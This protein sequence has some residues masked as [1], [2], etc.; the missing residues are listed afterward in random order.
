MFRLSWRKHIH[1]PFLVFR[2]KESSSTSISQFKM[3][4][5]TAPHSAV[6][7]SDGT[8]AN[9]LPVPGTHVSYHL[10]GHRADNQDLPFCDA[11]SILCWE[12][13]ASSASRIQLGVATVDP[14][15]GTQ[16]RLRLLLENGELRETLGLFGRLPAAD[17]EKFRQESALGSRPERGD[18]TY[19]F[20]S[21][22]GRKGSAKDSER[23]REGSARSSVGEGHSDHHQV[24]IDSPEGTGEEAGL[25][26]MYKHLFAL[27]G[28]GR[29][30]I[31]KRYFLKGANT[32][33]QCDPAKKRQALVALELTPALL[34]G[35]DLER[36]G[37]MVQATQRDL[38][39]LHLSARPR[40]A[41]RRS[42]R[43]AALQTLA[44]GS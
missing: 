2:R 6:S 9:S 13:G 31:A 40:P 1:L 15:A 11:R 21:E 16:F 23:E 27:K 35:L 37:V 38:R 33:L 3:S 42:K 5:L 19:S 12:D 25:Q 18:W 8:S 43:I 32:Q 17:V 41:L 39:E 24:L 7:T 14:S 20:D 36:L 30:E 29:R 22:R 10:K 44:R 26:F 4:N 28:L 34:D